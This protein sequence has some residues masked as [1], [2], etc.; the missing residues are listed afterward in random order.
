M[1]KLAIMNL[2]QARK[3]LSGTTEKNIFQRRNKLIELCGVRNLGALAPKLIIFLFKLGE[4]TN[5]TKIIKA[6]PEETR[7]SKNCYLIA[8]LDIL[9]KNPDDKLLNE[10]SLQLMQNVKLSDRETFLLAGVSAGK[11]LSSKFVITFWCEQ[12]VKNYPTD[13]NITTFIKLAYEFGYLHSAIN[14]LNE[15]IRTF[16]ENLNDLNFLGI[17]Q[18]KA[19]KFRDAEQTY[20]K[21]LTI[22]KHNSA[23]LLNYASVLTD[24]KEYTQALS[25]YLRLRKANKLE[26]QGFVNLGVLYQELQEYSN[27]AA[28]YKMADK[29]TLGNINPRVLEITA[30]LKACDFTVYTE[31][32][33][34]TFIIEN[35]Q[36]IRD[37]F[38]LLPL[39]KDQGIVSELAGSFGKMKKE[40]HPIPVDFPAPEKIMNS[41]QKL[42]IGYFS[43]DLYGHAVTHLMRPI[44]K[45]HDYDKFEII[46]FDASKNP[47]DRLTKEIKSFSRNYINMRGATR[48]NLTLKMH[49]AKLDVAIDLTGYTSNGRTEV[50]SKDIA[51]LKAHYLGFPGSMNITSYSHII[52]DH[53]L[54]EGLETAV[55]E[56]PINLTNGYQIFDRDRPNFRAQR[57]TKFF[58]KDTIVLG[59]VANTYKYSPELIKAWAQILNSVPKSIFIIVSSNSGVKKNILTE[60]QK[61]GVAD[62]RI[63]FLNRVP[64]EEYLNVLHS[65]D[66]YL[67]AFTYAAGSTA[68][69]ILWTG[70]PLLSFKGDAYH[71]R[72]SSS[73]NFHLGLQNN[74]AT[75][76]EQ[77]V[78][79]AIN[80][81]TDPVALSDLREN[82]LRTL[83]D[84]KF[85]PKTST[86]DYEK[87]IL[88]AFEAF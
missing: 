64:Y 47:V 45:H 80:M 29:L 53:Y 5:A 57:G 30:R 51:Y 70:T 65:F 37:V 32:S 46:L 76:V 36:E 18:R 8:L 34:K 9:H 22:D 55:L 14:A 74:I 3:V 40:L 39:A 16:G 69:D 27:A 59:S 12:L 48:E 81:L 31:E 68:N 21:A 50:F 13:Q 2:S 10:Q 28:A 61:Y 79:K 56:K 33:V 4:F 23:I 62:E 24:L 11:I 73:L 41:G 7:A 38:G 17:V 78:A 85:C 25:I 75:N 15:K 58:D 44:F 71:S 20:K 83:S 35:S 43:A 88:D 52:A 87:K 1:G 6:Y 42:R 72:M 19:G 60:F 54:L 67:D 77:Y 82:I 26:W 66:L 86:E 84:D 63:K 49:E